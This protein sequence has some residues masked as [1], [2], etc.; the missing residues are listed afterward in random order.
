M[1]TYGINTTAYVLENRILAYQNPQNIGIGHSLGGLL[2]REIANDDKNKNT[3]NRNFGGI[4]TVG[5]PMNGAMIVNK[6]KNGEFDSYMNHGAGE[7]AKGPLRQ[8]MGI[9]YIIVQSFPAKKLQDILKSAYG[10]LVPQDQTATDLQEKSDYLE[11]ARNY[12]IN[13]PKVS[14][15]GNE[16]RP[17]HYR[18]AST[19]EGKPDSYYP[20]IIN[21]ARGV[22]NSNYISNIGLAFLNPLNAYRA[23]GWK[24]GRDYLDNSSET[25]W[26]NLIGAVRTEKRQSCYQ[27]FICGNDYSCY[28][29][30]ETYEDYLACE[31]QCHRQVCTTITVHYNQP[32]DGL[33]H[34]STQ[35]GERTNATTSSWSPNATFESLGANHNE[36]G[37]HPGTR[38]NLILILNGENVPPFFETP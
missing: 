22:Y 8:L 30:I 31:A 16:N 37:Q 28:Q 7:L 18:L 21:M 19:S 3:P 27:E 1:T 25:G 24:A 10:N 2:M 23:A 6:L 5:S 35:I 14:I 11:L 9:S 20:N 26:N 12:Y 36:Y 32:S 4:I 13:L 38:Q 29:A 33:L 34:K 17:V 15:Y